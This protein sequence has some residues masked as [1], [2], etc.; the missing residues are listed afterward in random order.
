MRILA[1]GALAVSLAACAASSEPPEGPSDQPPADGGGECNAET[2]QQHVGHEATS[3]MGAAI[4]KDSGARTLRWGPPN[5]AWTM[6]Y[7]PDRVNVKYDEA[8]KITEITCG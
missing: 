6:D 5:S 7:R 8:K 1:L 2:A 4:L 3:E